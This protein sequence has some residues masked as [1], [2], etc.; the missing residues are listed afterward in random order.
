MRPSL[1]TLVRFSAT[2]GSRL[3]LS[4]HT[5]R[6]L[7]AFPTEL[8]FTQ[9]TPIEF[10]RHRFCLFLAPRARRLLGK[11][12]DHHL[13]VCD[14]SSRDMLEWMQNEGVKA[15][16][17]WLTRKDLDS[18]RVGGMV[19]ITETLPEDAAR[20]A[21]VWY[22][23]HARAMANEV[24]VLRWHAD[25][26]FNHAQSASEIVERAILLD[27]LFE[28]CVVKLLKLLIEVLAHRL[29]LSVVVL[30][31]RLELR[32]HD[33]FMLGERL[34]QRRERLSKRCKLL[35][36]RTEVAVQFLD[37]SLGAT[38]IICQG[39]ELFEHQRD[40]GLRS[41]SDIL[42][43]AFR[44]GKGRVKDKGLRMQPKTHTVPGPVGRTEQEP[45]IVVWLLENIIKSIVWK[46][47]TV[48]RDRECETK[49]SDGQRG[50]V[51]S[52]RICFHCMTDGWADSTATPDDRR[53]SR[54]KGVCILGAVRAAPIFV[55]P[56]TNR[57]WSCPLI[58]FV[59]PLPDR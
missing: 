15:R 13:H 21:S 23:R 18:A 30:K 25:A 46:T 57:H 50:L 47:L 38:N 27:G 29:S 14:P 51:H 41:G 40:V 7:E 6:L 35:L 28:A 34:F 17:V 53:S 10:H 56:Q 31:H 8:S 36:V 11:R 9:E 37:A 3:L 1:F 39:T 59:L 19:S 49:S 2:L 48:D 24:T 45:G 5:R 58:P 55:T 26:T 16:E 54:H 22:G 4:M 42:L 32:M 43:S 20:H 12:A 33:F 52:R 44:H